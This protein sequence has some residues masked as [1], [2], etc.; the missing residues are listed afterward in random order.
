MDTRAVI[1]Q[2][3]ELVAQHGREDLVDSL[4]RSVRRQESTELRV[5][6]V[7]Q[8]KQGKS[9]LVNAIL[10]APVCPVDD[11]IATSVPMEVAYGDPPS[12][13]LYLSAHPE[14]A[15]AADDESVVTH[16][17]PIDDL[18]AFVGREAKQVDGRAVVGAR[19]RLPR[20]LLQSGIVLVDTPGTG[21][22]ASVH[23]VRT[24]AALHTAD[25][26]LFV[27][28]ASSEFTAPELAFLRQAL[29][30]CPTVICVLTKIDL[31]P[32]W[33]RV[34][35]LD[36]HHLR[37]AG[38]DLTI[39]PVSATMR[40]TAVASSDGEL[41]EASG[42]LTLMSEFGRRIVGRRTQLLRTSTRHDVTRALDSLS[43][44]L[45]NEHGALSDPDSVPA[46][47]AS[48][49]QTGQRADDLKRRSARW[50]TT[51]SDG[52]ADLT[53][54]LDYDLRD[55][56]RR[57]VREA[58]TAIEEGDPGEAWA[59]FAGWV[60]GRCADAVSATFR[61]AD[62]NAGW[63]VEQVGQH[64]AE[65]ARAS[66]PSF[67]LAESGGVAG[68]VPS[69]GALDEGHLNL[70]QK[71]YIGVRGSYGGV[72]MT[73]LMTGLAGLA[74][75][76]PISVGAGVILGTK[77]FREDKEQRLQR[78]RSEAKVIVRKYADDVIF[79][80][81]KQLRDRLRDVQRTV[82]EYYTEAAAD[83]SRSLATSVQQAQQAAEASV[84]ERRDR[85]DVV[86]A[87][88]TRVES[89]RKVADT[90]ERDHPGEKVGAAASGARPSTVRPERP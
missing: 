74:L 58:E 33:R 19:A 37:K 14:P 25:A 66:F 56:V 55:R 80:I 79:Y 15:R 88:L 42:F 57:V 27:S 78:R 69:I 22:V 6:V 60:E 86:S 12:A 35:E 41:N 76:N 70:A 21:G 83:M 48:L 63:L 75:V 89:L 67:E 39:V 72:L 3:L 8:F 85:L 20:R 23:T 87:A 82:R 47:T 50:Q 81:G 32:D 90:L 24:T 49:T 52:V 17:I 62:E 2:T 26:V 64:F 38:L 28:D 4:R 45:T 84:T 7:G 18:A 46:L 36:T 11:D 53:S 65:E 9:K 73:G 13:T 31:F 43:M 40:L 61:W 68:A 71:V 59:E 29:A 44:T 51:L 77:A 5:L 54:D 34:L 16:D 10:N 30:A 1:E